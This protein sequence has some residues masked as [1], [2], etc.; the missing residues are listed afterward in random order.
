[1]EDLVAETVADR[2]LRVGDEDKAGFVAALLRNPSDHVGRENLT[3]DD[4]KALDA[5]AP[6]A[7]VI[8]DPF[9][10]IESLKKDDALARLLELEEDQERTFFEMGGVLSMIQKRKWF[11]PCASLDE[12]VEK[13]TAIS[14]AKARALIQIYDAVVKSGLKWADVQHIEW[15]KL[16]A[17]ARVLNE[18]TADHWIEIASNHSKAEVVKLAR[19]HRLGSAKQKPGAQ[20]DTDVRTFKLQGDQIQSIQAAIEKAK[21]FHGTVNNSSALEVICRDYMETA[22]TLMPEALV[23]MFVEYL[24]TLDKTAAGE[25]M[26]AVRERVKHGL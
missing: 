14:R 4:A 25:I 11:D 17:I 6:A 22:V 20:T 2:E 23:G 7:D 18:K 24:N 1:M 21:K 16:R 19:E 8:V 15:T 13:N 26:N 5:Q 9:H 3:D 10:I 12:W